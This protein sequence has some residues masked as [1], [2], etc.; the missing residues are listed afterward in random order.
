MQRERAAREEE[1]RQHEL[2]RERRLQQEEAD[3][4]ARERERLRYRNISVHI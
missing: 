4:V 3:R 2:D 1:R